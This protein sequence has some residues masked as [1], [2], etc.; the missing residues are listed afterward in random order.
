[1]TLFEQTELPCVFAQ[2][3]PAESDGFGAKQLILFDD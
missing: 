2:Y 3:L 1:V